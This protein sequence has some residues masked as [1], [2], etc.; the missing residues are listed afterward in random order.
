MD[1][2]FIV[3][4]ILIGGSFGALAVSFQLIETSMFMGIGAGIVAGFLAGL[5]RTFIN[6][7]RNRK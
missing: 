6:H 4:G 3:R 7:F 2:N 1:T 5:T